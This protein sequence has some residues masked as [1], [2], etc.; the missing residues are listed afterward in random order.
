MLLPDYYTILNRCSE[1]DATVFEIAL[2]AACEVYK[3]HFPETPVS[4][5]VCNI[6]M[7]KECVEEVVGKPLI[8]NYIQ[9]CR[10]TTLVTPQQH[11]T[12]EVRVWL[13]APIDG[14]VKIRA[15]IGKGELVYLEL[16]GE[17]TFS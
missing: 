15:T 9:Q 5:G 11:P 17:A 14:G 7:V 3:G 1:G 16:K 8:L 13:V 6:Q 4:P 2:N 12:V 10:L